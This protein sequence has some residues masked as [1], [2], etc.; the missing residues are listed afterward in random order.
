MYKRFSFF[1]SLLV[2]F[3]L[4]LAACAP[5]AS[6]EAPVV[7]EAPPPA[8]EETEP[9]PEPEVEEPTALPTEAPPPAETEAPSTG[10]TVVVS[11]RAAS[12]WVRNFNP[13]APDPINETQDMIYEPLIVWNPVLG[14][15]PTPWLATGYEYSDDLLTLTFTLREG[16]QWSDGEDFN[17][18]DVVFTVNLL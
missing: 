11:H 12:T 17:A 15:E 1:L 5:A 16:V 9:P 4:I 2:A 7:T 14:G 3:G 8:V 10:G 18:D 13:F 6:P